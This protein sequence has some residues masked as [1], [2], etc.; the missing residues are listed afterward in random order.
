MC[1]GADALVAAVAAAPATA[2]PGVATAPAGAV[3][4]GPAAAVAGAPAAATAA[5]PA[6]ATDL[7]GGLDL[8]TDAA[9]PLTSEADE[10][11]ADGATTTDT[12]ERAFASA[13][14][15]ADAG[16]SEEAGTGEDT[17][18]SALCCLL[19]C[20]LKCVLHLWS[21]STTSQGV[22]TGLRRRARYGV[23]THC[24]AFLFTIAQRVGGRGSRSGSRGA[25]RTCSGLLHLVQKAQ[26]VCGP[27][28]WGHS[29]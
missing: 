23:V 18:T 11:G 24:C 20:M 4:A 1:A 9:A 19:C 6:G 10:V 28:W 22:L 25:V 5:A 13:P 16:T 12:G 21:Y 17:A 2:L 7:A 14:T 29:C 26:G 15:T 8:P 27:S 3:A